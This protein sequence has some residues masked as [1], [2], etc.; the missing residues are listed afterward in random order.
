MNTFLVTGHNSLNLRQRMTSDMYTH[1]VPSARHQI[2][3]ESVIAFARFLGRSPDLASVKE[4]QSYCFNPSTIGGTHVS[5][6]SMVAGLTFFFK[7][8]LDRGDLA[9]AMLA[10]ALPSRSVPNVLMWGEVTSLVRQISDVNERIA[11]SHACLI[12]LNAED[13]VHLRIADID[14]S[15]MWISLSPSRY[16]VRHGVELSTYQLVFMRRCWVFAHRHGRVLERGWLIPGSDPT[17]RMK[18][19]QLCRAVRAAAAQAGIKQPVSMKK[20][21]MSFW[22][23]LHQVRLDESHGENGLEPDKKLMAHCFERLVDELTAAV[24]IEP[25]ETTAKGENPSRAEPSRAMSR[26]CRGNWH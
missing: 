11:A 7:V 23:H 25:S 17:K 12:G 3:I 14:S 21:H 20:L 24:L 9:A 5:K 1:N 4:V 19:R 10:P 22:N 26:G 6:G 18:A 8:T 13:L 2:Y 15:Q 16:K